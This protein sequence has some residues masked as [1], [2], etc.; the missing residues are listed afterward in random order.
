MIVPPVPTPAT[1]AVGVHA[2]ATRSCAQELGPGREVA[3][4]TRSSR[5]L[6]NCRGRK[7]PGVAAASSSASRIEPRKPPS[8]LETSRTSAPNDRMIAIRS[9]LI[10]S[11]MK[12][13]T[14]CPSARPM[15]QNEIPVLP[16]V[17]SMMRPPGSS[18]P[19]SIARRRMWYAIRSLM[20]PVMFECSAL[21]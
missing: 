21:A 2:P 5:S 3:C 17:A 20:L 13:V 19:V 7:L 18:S 14:G 16:L 8:S 12:I 11:G 15:A 1:N 10:Q 9:A 4:A 6:A